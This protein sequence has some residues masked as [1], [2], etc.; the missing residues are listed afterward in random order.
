[1]LDANAFC[2]QIGAR[3]CGVQE[4]LAGVTSNAAVCGQD[5]T[6]AWTTTDCQDDGFWAQSALDNTATCADIT[7]DNFLARCCADEVVTP[8]PTLFPLSLA[9]T[10][11]PSTAS[12][13]SSP[14]PSDTIRDIS[15]SN[16]NALGWQDSVGGFA[17]CSQSGTETETCSETGLTL[18]EANSWCVGLG[19]RLCRDTELQDGKMDDTQCPWKTTTSVWTSTD[20]C[21]TEAVDGI[22]LPGKRL[23]LCED[24]IDARAVWTKLNFLV[25]KQV[26]SSR[27]SPP[28]RG[29]VDASAQTPCRPCMRPRAAGMCI[30]TLRLP[31]HL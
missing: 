9:P 1:M 19:A 2:M 17:V 11:I 10:P 15:A 14:T 22:Q 12:P 27:A 26:I 16:C 18:V 29:G 3:L 21:T 6:F 25:C 30:R 28:A 7:S 20:S 4:I 13:T 31:P 24:V 8:A 23:I 5:D